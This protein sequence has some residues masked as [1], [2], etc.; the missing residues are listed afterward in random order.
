MD[1]A[2]ERCATTIVLLS[3]VGQVN[4]GAAQVAVLSACE[5]AQRGLRVIFVIG[6]G[7][8]D[9]RLMAHGVEV[10]TLGL[11]PV[12]EQ[13]NPIGAAMAGISTLR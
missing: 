13:S 4:G 3:D 6:A 12:W 2:H 11:R 1:S 10:R 8:A 7:P 9:E 5:L